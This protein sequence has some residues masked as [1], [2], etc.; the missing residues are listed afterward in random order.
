VALWRVGIGARYFAFGIVALATLYIA[1]WVSIGNGIHKHYETPTPVCISIYSPLWLIAD[2]VWLVLVLGWSC[3]QRGTLGRRICLALD[4][5]VCL[6]DY[7][8]PTLFLD[9]GPFVGRP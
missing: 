2:I 3:V 6:S 5:F 4:R 1:L 8:H 7:V 9:E